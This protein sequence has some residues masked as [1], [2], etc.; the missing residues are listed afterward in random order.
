MSNEIVPFGKYKGKPVEALQ[1]DRAYC[2][3]LVGQDWLQTRFPELRTIIINN[4][5]EPDETPE[6]NALQ[7]RALDNVFVSGIVYLVNPELRKKYSNDLRNAITVAFEAQGVDVIIKA[8][9]GVDVTITRDDEPEFSNSVKDNIE[10][11]EWS[12]DRTYGKE[13]CEAIKKEIE[14]YRNAVSLPHRVFIEKIGIEIK[15]TMGDDY[16][17]VLRQ[18]KASRFWRNGISALVIGTYTGV[19][20]T[21]DQVRRMFEASGIR[22]LM[23]SEIEAMVATLPDSPACAP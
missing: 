12:L 14:E 11:L 9:G 1:Q 21:L 22:V 19:G 17:A 4:F 6:H 3:W 8:I 13:K 15:P 7:A 2:D 5:G 23:V 18:I 10:S 20:A 16:P